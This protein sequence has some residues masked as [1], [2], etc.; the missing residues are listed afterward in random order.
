M[1]FQENNIL[2]N[3]YP[4]I[5]ALAVRDVKNNCGIVE[6]TI[7]VIGFPQYFTPNNDG[8]NETFGGISFETYSY[9]LSI[10]NRWGNKIFE[11]KLLRILIN[12]RLPIIKNIKELQDLI[13]ATNGVYYGPY[14]NKTFID[15]ISLSKNNELMKK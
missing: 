1:S 7:S 4:G 11:S 12:L 2:E 14:G 15:F 9:L 8:K 6:Q 3:V 13:S 10:Y 5:Y